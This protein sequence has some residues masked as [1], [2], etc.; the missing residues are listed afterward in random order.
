VACCW[1]CNTIKA[2]RVYKSFEEAK[3]HVLAR[4]EVLR[5]AWRERSAT[6]PSSKR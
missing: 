5:R 4:R 6:A 1:A 2:K 3:A